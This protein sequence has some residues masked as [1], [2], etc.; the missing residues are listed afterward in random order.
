MSNN[1]I[2]EIPIETIAETEN[3]TIWAADEPDDEKTYHVELGPVTV[4]F[5]QEE[6]E[7]FLEMV[8]E[9]AE[10]S[11]DSDDDDED[12]EGAEIELDWGSLWFD[13]DEWT[14]FRR[15]IGQV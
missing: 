4:H 9:A 1:D 5:F 12:E 3:Y 6:W 10:E 7:E 13:D 15:L 2:P 8:R 14:E 11:G